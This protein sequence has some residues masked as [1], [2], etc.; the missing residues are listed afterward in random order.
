M[1][2]GL[3]FVNIQ[4]VFDDVYGV[5]IVDEEHSSESEMR[6]NLVGITSQ[7]GLVFVVYVYAIENDTRLITARRAEN[8]MV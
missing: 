7:Y 4:D 5:Y 3:D 1:D 8:W 2:H 6:F